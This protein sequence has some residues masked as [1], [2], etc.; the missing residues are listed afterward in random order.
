MGGERQ[1]LLDLARR[2]AEIAARPEQQARRDAVRALNRLDAVRPLVYCFPEGAWLECIPP[3]TL[4]CTDPP[5]R[6]WETRLRMAVYTAEVLRDDQPLDAAWNVPWVLGFSGC[7]LELG[8]QQPDPGQRRT[9]FIHPYLGLSL[10]SHSQ[11]GAAHYDAPLRDRADINRL[12][13][14]QLVVDHEASRRHLDL[15]HEL[16][17]GILEVRRRGNPWAIVGGF[18]VDVIQL[19]GMQE[20][21][22]DFYDDPAWV[23]ELCRLLAADHTAR[24]DQIE[25][26][27]YLTLNNGCEWIGTG[28]IGYSDQL[29]ASG[30]DPAHVRCRDVWGGLQAQDLVGISPGQFEEFFLPHMIPIMERFGLSHYGC[31]EPVHDWMPLLKRVRNLRRVSVSAWADVHR[32]AEQIGAHYVFSWKPNPAAVSTPCFDEAAIRRHLVENL[33]IVREHGCRAEVIMKDTHTVQGDPSRLAR[34]VQLARSAVA[35]VYR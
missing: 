30:F 26:G 3:A 6:A 22:L 8:V 7:G 27:G 4:A 14:Q 19:R 5:L 31:C 25:A 33:R 35:E 24:L 32:T 12:T 34:W 2:V 10:E 17:D 15:A 9:Y 23:H 20:L 13:P 28:G 18:P 29:P 16:F 11:L 21:M 1:V